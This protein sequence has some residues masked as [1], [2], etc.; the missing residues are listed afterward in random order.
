MKK[1]YQEKN[2][3]D[4]NN[5]I[6]K[7]KSRNREKMEKAVTTVKLENKNEKKLNKEEFDQLM[8]NFDEWE[9][10]KK[11]KLEKLQKEKEEE[12]LK[13]IKENPET[14]HE[15]NLKYNLNPKNYSI[16]ERL[17][18]E[19]IKKRKDKQDILSKIYTPP[20]KPEIHINRES[21][22]RGRL[23]TYRNDGRYHTDD[24]E[25]VI[26]DEENYDEEN[27]NESG[28][29]EDENEDEEE[30]ESD[31]FDKRKTYNYARNA[32]KDKKVFRKM[33]TEDDFDGNAIKKNKNVKNKKVKKEEDSN[34]EDED[35]RNN[36]NNEKKNVLIDFKLRKLL[37]RKKKPVVEKN[38]SIG[39]RKKIGF[40]LD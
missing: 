27:S 8:K 10:K 7:A 11:E 18:I 3:E 14:N 38:R 37:F 25:N 32:K 1:I 35:N 30:E 4:L 16:T 40:S 20:F 34:E 12:E 5:I 6:Q 24:D 36:V 31:G 33:K 17:Y 22:M 2:K 28:E 39:K 9:R 29:D 21:L 15:E 19:D 26:E 23:R 13:L